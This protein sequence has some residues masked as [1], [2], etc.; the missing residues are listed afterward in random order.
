MFL[1]SFPTSYGFD[2]LFYIFMFMLHSLWLSQSQ[3]IFRFF[4]KSIYWLIDVIYFPI[5]ISSLLTFP[6]GQVEYC[7]I[8]LVFAYLRNSPSILSDNL[9][10]W[11]ILG[12]RSFPF[13]TLSLSYHCKIDFWPVT[14]LQRNCLMALLGGAGVPLKCVVQLLSHV[15]VSVTLWTVAHQASLSMGFPGQEH[16][17]GLPF[18]PPGDLPDPGIKLMSLTLAGRFFITEPPV[19]LLLPVEF[20]F[21]YLSLLPFF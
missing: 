20:L 2:C 13:R 11:T 17:S 21:S 19:F 6:L 10:G 8:F 16:W 9:A 1:L 5:V 12:Y 3:K 14:F 4:Q 18:P 15:L 7:C